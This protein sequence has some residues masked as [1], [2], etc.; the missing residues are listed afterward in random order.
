MKAVSNGTTGKPT[1]KVKQFAQAYRVLEDTFER[2][3]QA[4]TVPAEAHASFL[5]SKARLLARWG[6]HE[7]ENKREEGASRLRDE[8][9]DVLAESIASWKECQVNALPLQRRYVDFRLARALNDYAYRQRLRGHFTEAEEAMRECLRMKKEGAALPKSLA[10]SLSEYSQILAA[11]G[12]IEEAGSYNDQAQQIMHTLKDHAGLDGDRGMILVERGELYLLQARID[13]AETCF[14]EG[15]DLTRESDSR[16][17]FHKMAVARLEWIEQIRQGKLRYQLDAPWFEQYAT[18]VAYDELDWLLQGG[19]FTI[20]E[21]KEWDKLFEHR[22]EAPAK[23]RMSELLIRSRQREFA[24][25]IE[26]EREP[27]LHY[28]KIPIDEIKARIRGFENIKAEI[29]A[30]EANAVVRQLYLDTIEE[31][32]SLLR[33]CASIHANDLENIRKYNQVLYGLPSA[34]EMKIALHWLFSLLERARKHPQASSLVEPL[35]LQL[36][37][38]HL[39]ADD[40][41]EHDGFELGNAEEKE[42]CQAIDAQQKAHEKKAFSPSAVQRFFQDVFYSDYHATDWDIVVEPAR[43]NTYIEV[44]MRL[45]SLPKR[46]FSTEKIRQLLAEEIETHAFRSMAGRRSPLALLASGTARYSSTEEGLAKYYIQ[47]VTTHMQ[48]KRKSNSWPGTLAIG[49][50]AGVISP[51]LTFR[52]LCAFLEKVFFVKN[53][54]SGGYESLATAEEAAKQEALKRTSRTVRGITDLTVPGLC[55]LK[56]RI[57][58]QGALDVARYV[59]KAGDMQQLYVG[60]MGIG[61]IEAMKELHIVSPSLPHLYL[62]LDLNLHERIAAFEEK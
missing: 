11:L 37:Q 27:R 2:I 14:K 1:R 46:S 15:R 12:R 10:T 13:D 29:S 6:E 31:H 3:A 23:A 34:A 20:E 4:G 28:P 49:L 62:A 55:S 16:Q 19:P 35:L 59:E 7:E 50:M 56:D 60:K 30:K 52:S 61:Q 44:D 38:W 48:G 45:L 47:Q 24:K 40:F 33:L 57:Y 26:E 8:C 25:C 42:Q 43:E 17:K 21:Q 53:V 9:V 22:Q 36:K 5:Y 39:H 41:L 51:P 32:L 54:L 58:L 18:L